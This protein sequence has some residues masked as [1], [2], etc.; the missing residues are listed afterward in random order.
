L[1]VQHSWPAILKLLLVV[2]FLPN[3][4]LHLQSM[5]LILLHKSLSFLCSYGNIHS[6][7]CSFIKL[8]PSCFVETY[9]HKLSLLAN[10][11]E[12]I[13]FWW[14]CFSLCWRLNVV[15]SILYF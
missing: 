5:S 13:S 12:A 9:K 6:S 8:P 4:S 1:L 14:R 10:V 3:S 2:S 7:Y 15:S 11:D